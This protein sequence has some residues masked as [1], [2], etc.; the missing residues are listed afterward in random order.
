MKKI[1]LFCI[2]FVA[3]GVVAYSQDAKPASSAEITFEREMYDYGTIDYASDGTYAFKFYKY[4]KR[5]LVITNATGSCGCTV[6]KWP[7]EPILKGQSSFINVTYDT[8]RPGPFTKTVT[9]TSNATSPSKVITIKGVVRTQ[10]QTDNQ[11]PFGKE[12]GDS[13]LE[14]HSQ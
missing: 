3:M 12:G 6:P 5:P 11:M 4:G 7:K 2:C 8:K 9:I 1:L 13:P 10:E 14:N